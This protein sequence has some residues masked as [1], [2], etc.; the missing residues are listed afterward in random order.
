MNKKRRKILKTIATTVL[1]GPFMMFN[2]SCAGTE[3]KEKQGIFLKND[4][5]QTIKKDYKGNFFK[6][7]KFAGQYTTDVNN[8]TPFRILKWKLSASPKAEAKKKDSFSLKII[9]HNSLPTCNDD[10]IMWLGHASFLIHL[11]GKYI[12]TDPCLTSPPFVPRQSAIPLK[13][14]K[15]KADYLLISHG[16][17][18]HLDSDTLQMLNGNKIKALVPL[19]MGSVVKSMN[20]NIAVQEAGWYQQYD[21]GGDI[22]FFLL[23]A[24]HWHKRTATDLNKVLWGSY[25]IRHKNKTIYFAGDTAFA[26]HFSEIGKLFGEIDYAILPIGAY[27]PPYI[28]KNNHINPKE[29]VRAFHDL[30]AKVFIPM[31]YGT[32]DLTDEPPGEPVRWLDTMVNNGEVKG[33][34]KKQDVG[35]VF[36]I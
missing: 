26:S 30:K 12:I 23:P 9:K 1:S 15:L 19:Q 25:V 11:N 16:H 8:I 24:Q 18:D 33:D 28:M 3:A 13:I 5:L 20:D 17:Y 21:V 4:K 22:E 29:A 14:K 31:H 34:V 32:F 2:S 36:K 10:Y 6:N 27:D 35:T 7:G